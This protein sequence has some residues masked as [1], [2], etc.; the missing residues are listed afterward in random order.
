MFTTYILYSD[1]LGRY[2][3]G[4]TGDDVYARLA[5]HLTAHKGFTA[6]AKDWK[7]VYTERFD[8]KAE[9]MKRE[10]QWKAWKNNLRIK[11]LIG[12]SSTE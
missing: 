7:L 4:F 2:Y 6:K 11:Q 8:T 3:I 5:K 1:L 12:R 9:A 10:R